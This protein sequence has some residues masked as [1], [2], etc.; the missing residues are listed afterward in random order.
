M[1]H[2]LK[3]ILTPMQY[4][5]LKDRLKWFLEPDP[6]A[7]ENGDYMIRSIYFDTDSLDA[8]V[9][10]INGVDKRRKYRIRFYNG[11]ADQCTLECKEKHGTRVNK[12]SEPLTGKEAKL[13]MHRG[14]VMAEPELSGRMA[15]WIKKS[16]LHPVVAVDYV[17]EAYIYPVSNVRVTFDKQLSAGDVENALSAPFGFANIMGEQV[18]LEVKYDEVLPL[19]I[20]ELIAN[21]RPVHTAASKYVMCMDRQLMKKGF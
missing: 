6:H 3:Y 18:I 5:I 2:E 15:L 8:M 7:G 21:V 1:R 17:R 19:H 12:I 16:E 11:N 9:E 10:K 4:R 20:S 13:L 14:S